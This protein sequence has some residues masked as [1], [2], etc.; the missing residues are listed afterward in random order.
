MKGTFG[1]LAGAAALAFVAVPAA[2]QGQEYAETAL[3]IIPSGQQGSLLVPQDADVQAHMYDNLTPLADQVSAADL[4]GGAY[5]KSELF[6]VGPDGPTTTENVPR[7]GVTIT[8]DRFHVPHVTGQTHDDGVWAAGWIAAQDRSLLMEVA[9]YNGRVAALDVP[10]ITAISLINSGQ[11]FFP[12]D[13]T[14]AELAKQTQVLEAAGPEGQALLHDI[15]VFLQGINAY[16]DINSPLTSDWT[17]NDVYALNAVKGQFLGQG[18]GDEV[19]R[20]EFLGQLQD[21]MGAKKGRDAF[22]DLRQFKNPELPTTIDGKFPYGRTPKDAKGSVIVDP[23]SFNA[24]PALARPA[25]NAA[26]AEQTQAS[27]TLMITAEHSKTGNPLMVGGPQIGYLYP[28]FTYEIDMHAGDL[29]WRGA[30]SVPFPGYLLIGRG[31]D[32]ANT[33]TS[34]SGDIIDQYVEKLCGGNDRMYTYKGEC[35]PMEHFEAGAIG[36]QT[37][38]FW[39]TVHGPVVGYATVDGERV[40][41]SS[42]RSSY[43]QDTLDQLFFRRLSNGQVHSPKSFF[44]AAALT[45]QTFNSFYIDSEHVAEYTSGKLPIRPK[46]VDPALPALGTGKHEWRGFLAADK[47]P[48][49]IDPEDGTMTNWNQGVAL[50]FGAAD[51]EWGRNGSAARADLLDHNLARLATKKG[52]WTLASVTAA[53]NAAATQDV[54]A[55]DTVPLLRRLLKGSKAPSPRAEQML[56]ILAQWRAAG[57]SRLD[58]DLDGEIDHPGAAI[59]DTAW[60]LIA[61]ATMRPRLG[62]LVEELSLLF[63]RFD[64]PPGGQYSGWYQYFDKDIRALLDRPVEGAFK[65]SYCGKGKLSACQ[66]AVWAA[67]EAAGT[68]LAAAQGADPA[69]WRSDANRERIEFSPGLMQT[70][71]RYTNRPSGIQQVIS[72]SGH[73]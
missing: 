56:A 68:D 62:D 1:A 12:S 64:L 42:K 37:I 54:R 48:H 55:I 7:P 67:I 26:A 2:A 34:A 73:R 6:G 3:N 19:Q 9:R 41:I 45:P 46:T 5:F 32:F 33:L 24:T 25:L 23:G 10:G 70:T 31:Q 63:S 30:T 38:D 57:G 40:A 65:V 15:D 50:G 29:Q 4:A 69:A 11:Q 28:G 8:R 22:D 43:G 72:F 47:H 66:R 59:M 49:G 17:R 71:M 14:E 52:K 35:L 16:L 18:G 53:M 27:N 36:T 39:R 61:D 58:R 21:R 60:P 51:D 44:K 13:A 20:S